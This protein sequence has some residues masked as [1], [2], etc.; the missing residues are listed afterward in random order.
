MKT[1]PL[2]LITGAL[3]L[4]T[5]PAASAETFCV[6]APSCHATQTATLQDALDAAERTFEPDDVFVGDLGGPLVGP[7]TYPSGIIEVSNSVA[8]RAFEG[9]HPVLTAPVGSPVL[10]LSNGSP[11]GVDVRP[12]AASVGL[13]LGVAQ[14]RDVAVLGSGDVGI[15]ALGNVALDD[16]EIRG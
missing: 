5:A 16:V 4:A 6:H 9:A 10:T 15:R 11:S 2:L 14:L 12:G 1:L 3:C 7:F 13:E 8:I